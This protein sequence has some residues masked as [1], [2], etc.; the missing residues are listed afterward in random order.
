M[1]NLLGIYD[2]DGSV[3]EYALQICPPN[4]VKSFG[5]RAETAFLEEKYEF[6]SS[7]D[8]FI[9]NVTEISSVSVFIG[10]LRLLIEGKVKSLTAISKYDLKRMLFSCDE[11]EL[12]QAI[13]L[14]DLGT[15]KLIP[16]GQLN[17]LAEKLCQ[18]QES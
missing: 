5:Q 13:D 1:R 12:N 6:L 8:H 16:S 14:A 3:V 2:T 4:M 10:A 9:V 15:L 7:A 17:L 11:E 18:I